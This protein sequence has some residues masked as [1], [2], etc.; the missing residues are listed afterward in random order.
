MKRFAYLTRA[1]IGG[2][3]FAAGLFFSIV[4]VWDRPAPATVAHDMAEE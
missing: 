2:V 4:A 3:V 1:R